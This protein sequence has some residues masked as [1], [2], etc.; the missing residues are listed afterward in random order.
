MILNDKQIKA[1][2]LSDKPLISPFFPSKVKKITVNEVETKVVSF[3]NSEFGYDITLGNEFKIPKP[4]VILDPKTTSEDDWFTFTSD[5]P[6][7][8][9]AN[10][11]LIASVKERFIMPLNLAGLGFAKS[12]YSRLGLEVP[13]FVFE[14]GWEGYP[15]IRISNTGPN[16]I[17][18]YPNEGFTQVIFFQGE[19]PESSYGKDGKY[20]DQKAGVTI[21]KV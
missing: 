2:A 15:T 9:N 11:F 21:A 13:S 17:R 14:P 10:S 8:M 18:L 3:G 12:T 7:I 20:Q 4:G 1:L 19:Q 6:F 16:P 5:K